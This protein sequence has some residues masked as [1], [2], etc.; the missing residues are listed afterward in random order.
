MNEFY[1]GIQDTNEEVLSN[2]LAALISPKELKNELEAYMNDIKRYRLSMIIACQPVEIQEFGEL[3]RSNI[4]HW[5][6]AYRKYIERL[7][8]IEEVNSA[9]RKLLYNNYSKEAFD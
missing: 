5:N 4:D 6:L 1:S 8:E 7:S 3:L 2:H 9:M